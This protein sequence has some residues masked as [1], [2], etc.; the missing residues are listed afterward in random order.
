MQDNEP[1]P[2][3]AQRT[4][5]AIFTA[6][7]R[8]FAAHGYDG[9]S[10]RDIASEAGVDPALVIRYF[11][12]KDALFAEVSEFQLDLPPVDRSMRPIAGEYMVRNFLDIWEGP[13]AG[14]AFVILLRSAAANERAAEKL[15][16]IFAAQ[17]V[18]TVTA[19]A[20]PDGAA[21]RA[22]LIT[23]HMLGLALCR[24]I[25]KLPPVVDLSK[26]AIAENVGRA[27]QAYLDLPADRI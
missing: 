5:A 17:V 25:L 20:G 19:L 15:R 11:G 21:Q 3:K 8:L 1:K 9:T 6:A 24:Y 4:R 7:S 18:P 13:N 12:S 22:G 27:V 2:S 10:V 26:D 16:E 23:S 14:G